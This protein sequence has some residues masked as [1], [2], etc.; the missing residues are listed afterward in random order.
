[1]VT[2]LFIFTIFTC[3][4]VNSANILGIFN[5]GSKIHYI[6]GEALLKALAQRGHN[7]TMAS[8]YPLKEKLPNYT[9]LNLTG[10]LE[11]QLSS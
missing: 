9:D 8:A 4:F 2:K 11:D 10:I 6:L 3:E 7:V 1:M 5:D